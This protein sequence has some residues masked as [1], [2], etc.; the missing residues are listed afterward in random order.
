MVGLWQASV[1]RCDLAAPR[2]EPVVAG[3]ILLGIGGI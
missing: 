2:G 1:E 3:A